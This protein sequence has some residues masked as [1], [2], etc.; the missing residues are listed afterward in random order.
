VTRGTWAAVGHVAAGVWHLVLRRVGFVESTPSRPCP[1]EARDRTPEPGTHRATRQETRLVRDCEAFF[2]GRYTARLPRRFR[3][4]WAWLN[5]LAHAEK[6]DIEALASKRPSKR[7][8]AAVF[9]AGELLG[10]QERDGW[11]LGWFQ[12]TF[13]VPLELDCM[14][15]RVRG[16][17]ATVRGVLDALHRARPDPKPESP[18]TRRGGGPARREPVS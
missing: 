16:P 4:Q 1:A 13:L 2:V 18:A 8:G 14:R 6:A 17:V 15:G 12:R 5:T 11:E 3:W 9:A 7:N 10:A